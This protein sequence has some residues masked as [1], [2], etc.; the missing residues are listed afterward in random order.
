M[1]T[2]LSVNRGGLGRFGNACYTIA[3]TIGIAVKSGQPYGFPEWISRDAE[4]FGG[5]A[6]S[7]GKYFVNELPEYIPG[8][9][10]QEYGY[11]W[12]YRDIILPTGS[13]D[14]NA[15]LQ[16]PKYFE[17]CMPLIRDTF[18]MKNEYPDND[19]VAIHWR[20]GDY[21]NGP[22]TYHPRQPIEY[23]RAA[24]ALF[25]GRE[26]SVFTDDMHAA[27]LMFPDLPISSGHYMDDFAFMKSHHSFIIANSS[28]SAFAATL[29]NQPGKQVVATS[30]WFGAAAGGLDG[31][32]IY[33]PDWIII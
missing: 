28:Y 6:E 33:E 21:T 25:P 26:F 18:R 7:M 29:A 16:S 20:A 31:S 32:A 8:V 13:W 5:I 10:Y 30:L 3:G 27:E 9:S 22:E 12:G 2:S 14:I 1:I 11:F 4:L 17:H 24:M 15:H 23:Y 19:R